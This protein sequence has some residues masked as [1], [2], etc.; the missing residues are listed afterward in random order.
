[1]DWRGTMAFGWWMTGFDE[2]H[3]TRFD[4]QGVPAALHDWFAARMAEDP[5][6]WLREDF[7]WSGE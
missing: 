2:A 7:D 5:D 1:M 6:F 3:G 4:D